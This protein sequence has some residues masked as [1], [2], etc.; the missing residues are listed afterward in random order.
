MKKNSIPH[1]IIL[2]FTAV[3]ILSVAA[4]A[5]ANYY[6][7]TN[8]IMDDNEKMAETCAYVVS[9]LFIYYSLLS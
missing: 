8:D 1:W 4:S 2:C 3:L 6:E 7:N 5:A 9:N